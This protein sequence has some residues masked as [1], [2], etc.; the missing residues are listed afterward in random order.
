M[1]LSFDE[2]QKVIQDFIQYQKMQPDPEKKK[3]MKTMNS[4]EDQQ[5]QQVIH[6][7]MGLIRENRE[8]L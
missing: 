3:S 5:S 8:S 2:M 7:I 4:V 6:K 1:K